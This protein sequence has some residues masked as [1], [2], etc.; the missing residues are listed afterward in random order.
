[1]LHFHT[2]VKSGR[3]D[4]KKTLYSLVKE[5]QKLAASIF[6]RAFLFPKAGRLDFWARI[7]IPKNWPAR[8]LGAHYYFWVDRL[9]RIDT[10]FERE[11]LDRSN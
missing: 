7:L 4:S 8:F 5:S 2:R 9:A 3:G 1:M 6:G 11:F 10:I